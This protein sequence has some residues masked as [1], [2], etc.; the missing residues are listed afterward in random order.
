[1]IDQVALVFLSL[2]FAAQPTLN[3]LFNPKNAIPTA[4]VIFTEI[5]KMIIAVSLLL[6]SKP[7]RV[8]LRKWRFFDCLYY[9]GIPAT[10]YAIQNIL[11]YT[12]YQN[13][14]GLTFNLINQA[15]LLTTAVIAFL[16]LGQRQTTRQMIALTCLFTSAVLAVSSGESTNQVEGNRV[17]GLVAVIT[18]TCLSGFGAVMSERAVRISNRNSLLFSAELGLIGLVF[19]TCSSLWNGEWSSIQAAGG[20]WLEGPGSLRGLIPGVTQALGGLV[21]GHVTKHSG[22]VKKGLAVIV[23][24]LL[25]AALSSAD[26]LMWGVAIP[27]AAVGIWL[28]S[29][30]IHKG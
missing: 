10:S 14:D 9:A 7:G 5:L 17:V 19:L 18:G 1:M 24:L 29:S 26:L 4:S 20:I 23:G 28:H 15:K 25:T 3:K 27:L 2:Q 12:A 22:S 30:K 13:I 6:S 21:I 16:I 8:A 11:I